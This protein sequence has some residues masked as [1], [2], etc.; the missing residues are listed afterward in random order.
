[1]LWFNF[2]DPIWREFDKMQKE[3]EELFD[4][5]SPFRNIN[6]LVREQFPAI[7]IGETSDNVIVYILAPGIDPSKLD[8]TIEKNIL[9]ISAERDAYDIGEDIDKEKLAKNYNRQER[10]NGKFKRV[11]SLPETVDPNKVNAEYKNGI[12][13]VTIGKK[14]EDKSKKI[15]VAIES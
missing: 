8:L 10:F 6:G 11:I 9:T 12:L 1:M 15:Q 14:E 5:S 13:V 3:I 4:F 7:N 2:G